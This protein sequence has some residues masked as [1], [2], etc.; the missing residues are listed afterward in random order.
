VV[1]DTAEF[2][3]VIVRVVDALEAEESM[4]LSVTL[5]VPA[6]A[7]VPLITPPVLIVR[8]AGSVVELKLYP[9][10]VPPVAVTVNGV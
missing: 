1:I 2:P 5:L 9:L 3:I 4:T 7:G 8:P 6:V 10:P